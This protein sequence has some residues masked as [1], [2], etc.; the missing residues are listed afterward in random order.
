V[1]GSQT[2]TLLDAASEKKRASVERPTRDRARY[3]H[4]CQRT[5]F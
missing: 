2:V 4:R 3:I 1:D 5:E